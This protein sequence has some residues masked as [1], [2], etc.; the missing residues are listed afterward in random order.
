MDL[1]QST[2]PALML[3]ITFGVCLASGFLPF[4]NAELF[5]LAAAAV[6]PHGLALL[7]VLCAA[8]G[9]LTAKTLMFMGARAATGS[10]RFSSNPR[11]AAVRARV[12][13][14]SSIG[15]L[16]FVSAAARLPPFYLVSVASGMVRMR[17]RT[18]VLSGFAGRLVRFAAI[19]FAPQLIMRFLP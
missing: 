18:F 4:V 16:V 1:L 12:A 7:I 15:T 19:A 9:Q 8:A 5:L 14:T 17:A 2:H 10:P 3:I 11:F 6:A 13:K